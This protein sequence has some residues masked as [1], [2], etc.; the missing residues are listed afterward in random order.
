MTREGSSAYLE[1][2]H[3]ECPLPKRTF[4]FLAD[5]SGI[6]V[7]GPLG[8]GCGS[9]RLVMLHACDSDIKSALSIPALSR[10]QYAEKYKETEI[11]AKT[12]VA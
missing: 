12:T 3:L 10:C 5:M 2:V 4:S 9:A 11:E 6:T 1:T 8:A 7:L